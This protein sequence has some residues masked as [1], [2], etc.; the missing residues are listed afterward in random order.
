MYWG[1]FVWS[2]FFFDGIGAFGILGDFAEIFIGTSSGNMVYEGGFVDSVFSGQGTMTMG[3]GEKY[4]GAWEDG[5]PNGI[6]TMTEADGT[7]E[8]GFFVDGVKLW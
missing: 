4:G 6:G 7:S 5:M 2:L 8:T 3:N 1:L